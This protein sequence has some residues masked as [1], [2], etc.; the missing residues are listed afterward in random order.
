MSFIPR[1]FTFTSGKILCCECGIVIEPNTANM[2][3]SCIRN[4]VDIT[5]GISRQISTYFCRGCSRYSQPPTQWLPCEWESKELLALCLRRVKG[6]NRVR[7]VDASFIWTEPHSK[8]IK[9]KISIQKEVF[10]STILQQ[11]LTIDVIICNQQCPDC[12]KVEA[13]NTWNSVVQVRQKVEHKRTFLYLEQLILKHHAEE[14]VTNIKQISEG[15][16]FFFSHRNHALKFTDFLN[17]VIPTRMKSSE[18]LI[19]E[20]VH[21]GDSTYKFTFSVEIIPICKDDLVILPSRIAKS[22]GGI[23]PLVLCV[24][25]ATSI[26]FIDPNTLKM[27][28]LN[29]SNYWRDSFPSLAASSS[30]IKFI[31]LDIERE[32]SLRGGH[33]GRGGGM[34]ENTKGKKYCLATCTVARASEFGHN[35][36]TFFARTHLGYILKP[37]NFVLGYD[38]TTSNFN[39]SNWDQWIENGKR[40]KDLPDVILVRKSFDH[41]R[42]NRKNRS[43]KLKNL[44][45]KMDLDDPLMMLTQKSAAEEER[46]ARDQERFMEE[47]EEDSELRQTINIYRNDEFVNTDNVANAAFSHSF[48]NS[49]GN[50]HEI[51]EEYMR[52]EMEKLKEENEDERAPEIPLEELLNS[53]VLKDDQEDRT[54]DDN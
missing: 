2:C 18:Q 43:W 8:R 30:L 33:G 6:L 31:V 28:E 25:V 38:L 23:C 1:E 48:T 12:A 40:S 24:K 5:D 47:L 52:D 14:N 9:I 37:G 32:E 21:S 13:K 50:V 26:H 39:D 27:M 19:S 42:R 44:K 15:L 35:S 11:S 29:T 3:I 49:I 45:N 16:D 7:L 17:A 46:M 10:S 41:L 34:E 36:T 54:M 20:D 51:K 53:L 4:K 22:F